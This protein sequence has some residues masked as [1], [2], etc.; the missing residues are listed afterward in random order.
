MSFTAAEPSWTLLSDY[1]VADKNNTD[2]TR[3]CDNM[4]W[5]GVGVGCGWGRHGGAGGDG[6]WSAHTQTNK[7]IHA[8]THTHA[9]AHTPTH[10]HARA[11]IHTNAH[12]HARTHMHVS[13][14]TRALKGPISYIVMTCSRTGTQLVSYKIGSLY[15]HK[16]R[17]I[18]KFK[19]TRI[20]TFTI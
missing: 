9:H 15:I 10:T 16:W 14:R 5:G 17:Q 8:H 19:E 1:C 13:T 11:H 6:G 12:I 3:R 2:T 7:N 4:W 18:A 20:Y